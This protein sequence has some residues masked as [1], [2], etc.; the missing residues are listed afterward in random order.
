MLSGENW[1]RASL[2]RIYVMKLLNTVHIVCSHAD[3]TGDVRVSTNHQR[4]TSVY[5]H[6]R[7]DHWLVETILICL[8]LF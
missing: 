4:Q 6:I 2:T 5:F 3:L 7:A 8:S 1:W